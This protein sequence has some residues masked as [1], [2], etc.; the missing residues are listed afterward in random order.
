MDLSI[1]DVYRKV[2]EPL[3]TGDQN[4]KLFPTN[5][6]SK[7]EKTEEKLQHDLDAIKFSDLIDS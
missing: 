4:L 3:L 2:P 7:I 6:V 5:I 1:A